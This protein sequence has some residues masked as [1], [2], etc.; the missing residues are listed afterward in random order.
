METVISTQPPPARALFKSMLQ[1]SGLYMAA[2]V[3]VRLAS[4]ILVPIVTRNLTPDKYGAL[5]LLEQVAVVL[6]LLLGANFS[7][8][9]GFFYFEAG[10]VK[11]KVVGTTLTGSVILGTI[12]GLAGWVLAPPISRL[13]FHSADYVFYLRM[14]LAAMPVSFLLEAGLGWL[15]VENRAA[16]YAGSVMLRITLLVIATLILVAGLHYKIGGVLGANICAVTLTALTITAMALHFHGPAFNLTLFKRMF[17]FALP[18]GFSSLALFVIHFGDR[19]VLPH[20][21]PFADLGIYAMAYKFGM[22]ISPV[23]AAFESYWSA[24]IF[25]ILKRPD[26][27]AV[28]ARTFTYWMLVLSFCVLALLVVSPPML[29][30]LM[31]PA[32]YPAATLIPVILVA[33][34]VRALGDFFRYLFVANGVPVYDATCNWTTAGLSLGSYFLLIPRYGIMGAALATLITFLLSGAISTFWSYRVWQYDLDLVRV[35]KLLAVTVG[36][37]A[38]HFAIPAASIAAEVVTGTLL[39]LACP[40]LLFLVRCPSP[41][42]KQLLHS[43]IARVAPWGR[44]N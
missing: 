42:E 10:A 18:M 38:I 20:Y 41:A 14:I 13:V 36:L 19:F 3:G 15:R 17:R 43:A 24:Q 6:S 35:G 8:A 16:V 28:F 11:S 22:L 23:Q 33:Y 34:Y 37:S 4:F 1:G 2:T 31:P 25:N 29:H 27:R 32:Y 9:L 12:A 26:A 7:A 39:L 21:R 5:D 40:L 30:R 44:F